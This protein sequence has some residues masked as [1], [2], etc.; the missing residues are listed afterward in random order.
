LD[1]KIKTENLKDTEK[2]TEIQFVE[3]GRVDEKL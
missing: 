1:G 3:G 2:K